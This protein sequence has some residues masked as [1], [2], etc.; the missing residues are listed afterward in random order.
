M[1]TFLPYPDFLE[2]AR[3]LDDKRLQ[4][5]INECTTLIRTIADDYDGGGW[6]NHPVTKM[7]RNHLEALIQYQSACCLAYKERNKKAHTGYYTNLGLREVFAPKIYLPQMPQWLGREDVHAAYRSNLLRKDP[8]HYGQFGW[9][10]P[11]D[12]DYV[13]VE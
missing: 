1:Q 7:W 4:N 5:Q 6:P 13:Y 10:E 8:E 12:L 11:D 9:S 3:C 2:S